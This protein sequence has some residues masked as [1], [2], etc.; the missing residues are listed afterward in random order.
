MSDGII[1]RNAKESD[2]EF[3]I[4]SIISAE[5]SGTDKIITCGVFSIS[6]SE[7]RVILREIVLNGIQDYEYSL[8]GFIVAEFEGRPIGAMVSWIE[9]HSGFSSAILK[10]NV[11][12]PYIK[13]EKKEDISHTLQLMKNYGI[14]RTP[15]TIQ[16]EFFYVLNEFRGRR[17]ISKLITHAISKLLFV[18]DKIKRV[19]VVLMKDNISSFNVLKR[20]GFEICTEVVITEEKILEIFPSDTKIQMYIEGEKLKKLL[21]KNKEE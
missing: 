14:R 12:I 13:Q 4:D 15:N 18:D 2:I 3:V 9:E 1:I 19:E 6:E 16:I 21:E 5:K 10:A 7:F 20:M 8:D 17:I 11:F